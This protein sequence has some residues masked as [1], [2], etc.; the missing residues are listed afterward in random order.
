MFYLLSAIEFLLLLIIINLFYRFLHWKR[1]FLLHECRLFILCLIKSKMC[2]L[3]FLLYFL[4]FL[5]WF[6]RD[7]WQ[8]L[9]N[10]II[11]SN[12]IKIFLVIKLLI[13]MKFILYVKAILFIIIDIRLLFIDKCICLKKTVSGSNIKL[14]ALHA[15]KFIFIIT[16]KSI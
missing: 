6:L 9:E 12:R 10:Y 4:I 16:C 3:L 15:K 1:D 14:L 7:L 11:R 5:L 2:F 13:I 8:L